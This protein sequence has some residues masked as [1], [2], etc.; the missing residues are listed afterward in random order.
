MFVTLDNT[1]PCHCEPRFVGAWQSHCEARACYSWTEEP[2]LEIASSPRFIGAPRNDKKSVTNHMNEYRGLLFLAI[3]VYNS[4]KEVSQM[5]L[6]SRLLVVLAVCLVSVALPAAPAQAAGAIITLSPESGVPG[7]EV[8]VYGHNFTAD[9]WVDIYYDVNGDEEWVDEEWIDDVKTNDDGDFTIPITIPKSCTG[10]HA[11]LAEDQEDRS[12]YRDFTVE[13]GLIVDPEEGPVGTNVTVAGRGFAEDEEDIELRYYLNGSYETVAENIEADEDGSWQRSFPIP[14]SSKGNHY[15]KAKGEQSTLSQ[16]NYAIF[17]VTPGISLGK[18]SGSVGENITMTGSG[19]E[20]NERD[21]TI[22]FAGKEVKTEIRAD[23]TGYWQEPF[24]VPEMP[25]DE[26]SVTAEGELTQDI[27][28]LSFEIEPDIVLSPDEG[29]VSIDLTV[30]GRGFAASKNVVIKYDAS[31][32]A[33]ASTNAKGSFSGVSF[34]VPESIH[35]AHQVTARDAANNEATAI[36][37][38]ESDPPDIPTLISPRDGSRV[39]LMGRVTPTFEW[40]EVSDDSGVRYSLQIATSVNVTATGKFADPIVSIPDIAGTNYTLNATDALPYGTY[41]W[42]VQAVDRAENENGWTA[43]RSFRA[44]LLPLWAF[45]FIIV[46]IVVLIG[47][48]VYFFVRRRG[49]HYY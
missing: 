40:S 4:K 22:L 27:S 19:F 8:T 18:S 45:I 48:L 44:G 33:T 14:P 31:Q 32:K 38:M 42:I 2:R 47:A 46:A 9:K 34:L 41:Y 15:I 3:F 24:E 23:N 25:T 49:I 28:E 43:A 6:L 13:P 36:F 16:V 20:A 30:T 37:T 5:R 29:H 39:G 7:E 21:I 1:L 11:V 12:A 17:E 35:G 26:Y 10:A